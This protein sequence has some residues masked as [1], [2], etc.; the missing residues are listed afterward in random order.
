MGTK[1]G[2]SGNWCVT[3]S[4]TWPLL[5]L[6]DK[7]PLGG[8]WD[9]CKWVRLVSWSFSRF[10]EGCTWSHVVGITCPFHSFLWTLGCHIEDINYSTSRV[11][12]L[13]GMSYE[14]WYISDQNPSRAGV[15]V[16]N[17]CVFPRVLWRGWEKKWKWL[18]SVRRQVGLC[19]SRNTHGWNPKAGVQTWPWL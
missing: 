16:I 8:L 5:I 2:P 9:F 3:G 18:T 10:W 17:E 15:K 12:N 14:S 7:K 19:P 6:V 11:L 13:I 4:L 1:H